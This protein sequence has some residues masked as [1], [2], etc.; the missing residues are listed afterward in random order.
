MKHLY[1]SDWHIGHK[2]ILRFTNRGVETLDEMNHLLIQNYNAQANSNT[3]GYFLGDMVFDFNE[4]KEV[5][6]QLNG[7]K[8]L[9]RGNHDKKPTGML[10]VGFDICL[11]EAVIKRVG[12]YIKLSHF[13]YQYPPIPLW[14]KVLLKEKQHDVRFAGRRPI[15]KGGWL[16]HGHTHEKEQIKN[17]MIHVGVDAWNMRPV[18]ES[19]I[20]SLINKALGERK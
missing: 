10:K 4:G 15:D 6:S 1:T 8:V 16:L 18:N 12:H 20:Q 2:N 3:I 5:L 17:K 7:L 11:E 9:V 13:P 19:D 14:R